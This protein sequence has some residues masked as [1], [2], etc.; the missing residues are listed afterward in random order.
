MSH[1]QGLAPVMTRVDRQAVWLSQIFA[2]WPPETC[3]RQT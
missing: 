3:L 2:T 1:V